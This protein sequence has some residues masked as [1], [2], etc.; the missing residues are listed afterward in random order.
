[1]L[2]HFAY[3]IMIMYSIIPVSCIINFSIRI[4]MIM[5]TQIDV[6]DSYFNFMAY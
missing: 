5:H 6:S 2:G 3:I 4:I 1:M